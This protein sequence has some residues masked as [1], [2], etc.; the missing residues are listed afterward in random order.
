MD[1]REASEILTNELGRFSQKHHAE[2]VPLAESQHVE[3]VEIRGA[4]GKAYHV[5]L[6][7]FWDDEPGGTIRVL[8]SVDDGGLR[9]FLPVTQSVLVPRT[10][11]TMP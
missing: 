1:K 10:A 11:S 6:Q 8:G 3:N 7:F 4:S 5:E 9:A 2:L